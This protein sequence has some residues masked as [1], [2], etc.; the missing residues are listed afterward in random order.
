MN[1]TASTAIDWK[2]LDQGVEFT[3]NPNLL[4]RTTKLIAKHATGDGFHYTVP[5]HPFYDE[6]EQMFPEHT[7]RASKLDEN[8]DLIEFRP[9]FRR[10]NTWKKLGLVEVPSTGIMKITSLGADFLLS[11][12]SIAEVI[13]NACASHEE[14]G[15]RP[16]EVLANAFLE[17]PEETFSISDI[18]NGI[19]KNYNF[20]EH[21][22]KEV[23]NACRSSEGAVSSTQRR[24]I[25]SIM[26]LLVGIKGIAGD[27]NSG[28]EINDTAILLE[29]AQISEDFDLASLFAK[30][31]NESQK[32]STALSPTTKKI[33]MFEHQTGVGLKPFKSQVGKVTD[34]QARVELLEKASKT[35]EVAVDAVASILKSYGIVPHEDPDSYDLFGEHEEAGHLFE[36]KSWTPR[37]IK[38]Q[39]RKAVSQLYEYRWRGRDIFPEHVELY[40]VLDR[41]PSLNL[42]DWIIEYITEDRGIHLAWVEGQDL[43][44]SDGS[45]FE[46]T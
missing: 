13:T 43:M 14:A 18:G 33:G 44:L 19:S 12:I 8:G 1:S 3:W 39:I 11:K 24:R 37:N 20:E 15:V 30:S 34:H 10:S 29:I 46:L 17:M 7:W 2:G 35:H 41:N 22:L 36:M 4:E 31:T 23:L 6:V 25:R 28:W 38:E 21:N 26:D 42:E 40:I 45:L 27:A 9:L 5:N 16:F 32:T